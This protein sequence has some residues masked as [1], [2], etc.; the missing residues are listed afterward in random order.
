MITL[1]TIGYGD[2]Y[3]VTPL[4]KFFAVII[5]LLGVGTIALPAAILGSEFMNELAGKHNAPVCPH[6]GKEL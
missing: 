2:V 4:G 1:T 6:C 3:P 5:A